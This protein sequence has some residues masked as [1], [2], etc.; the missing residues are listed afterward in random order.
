[1]NARPVN[2]GVIL[3]TRAHGRV[4]GYVSTVPVN[5]LIIS[6][7]ITLSFPPQNPPVTQILSTYA[8]Y[9]L[10]SVIRTATTDRTVSSE[11]HVIFVFS[12]STYF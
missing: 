6:N 7:Y 9:S 8:T 1:V 11:Q 12:S 10:S 3:D 5:S 4:H 2:N